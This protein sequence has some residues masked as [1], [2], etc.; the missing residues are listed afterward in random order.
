MIS[1]VIPLYNKAATI[2]RAVQSIQS[3]TWPDWE[4]IVVDDGSRDDGA[5]RVEALSDPR[6]RVVRQ[7]NQGV[8]VARNTGIQEAH[9][10][11][12]ALLDADDYWHAEHLQRMHALSLRY[13]D[14]ALLGAGYCYVNE[15]GQHTR[16][17]M[18]AAHLNAPE[19]LSEIEDFFA[20]A[21][22]QQ[23]L[24][25]N[26]SSVLVRKALTISL[27]GFP[28]GVTAGEDLLM[29]AKLACAGRV[30]VSAEPTSFYV[31]PPVSLA[32][33]SGFIRRPQLPDVV[34]AGLLALLQ[35]HPGSNVHLFLADWHRMRAVLWMEL[36]ERGHSL[37]DLLRAVR[38]GHL[39]R[40]DVICLLALALPLRV[41]AALLARHRASK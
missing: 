39:T 36:N 21:V 2:L 10:E 31:V 7:A 8:S 32:V 27:G 24:P 15:A 18:A 33:R 38:F 5:A 29:W 17:G 11:W 22:A 19:G 20:E 9:G 1:V 3:Q 35:R 30:A 28:A 16:A 26:S 25:F 4:L 40:K 37:A 34:G 13:P 14:A 6:I 23:H 41:R 12:V